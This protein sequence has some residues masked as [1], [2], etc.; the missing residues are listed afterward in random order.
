MVSFTARDGNQP[1]L[2]DLSKVSLSGFMCL[3]LFN[4]VDCSVPA[5]GSILLCG[6]ATVPTSAAPSGRVHSFPLNDSFAVHARIRG[7]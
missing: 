3:I 2:A 6:E 7:Y 4:F 5:A 1:Y